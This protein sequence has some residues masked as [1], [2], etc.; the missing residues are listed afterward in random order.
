VLQH[1]LPVLFETVQPDLCLY[2]AG[3]DVHKDDQLGLLALTNE[4]I[5]T[6]DRMVLEACLQA[7]V[8]LAAAIGGGYQKDHSHIVAR[9]MYLHRAAAE[10]V[11][12]FAAMMQAKR[13]VRA[14]SKAQV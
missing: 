7:G 2:N 10:C 3:V 8:P 12:R 13:L 1:V 4:G 6:R 14:A 5:S 9:H 11:P